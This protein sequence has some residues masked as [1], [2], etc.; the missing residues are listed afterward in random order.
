MLFYYILNGKFKP[1]M[2][3]IRVVLSKSGHVFLIFKKGQGRH[4]PPQPSCVPVLWIHIFLKNYFSTVVSD[5]WK[6]SIPLQK[7]VSEAA[8]GGA[9]YKKLFIEMW[10]NSQENTCAGVSFLIKLQALAQSIVTGPYPNWKW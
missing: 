8:T 10:Q 1:K 6:S 4:P 2:D 7:K 3:K 5:T 9:L